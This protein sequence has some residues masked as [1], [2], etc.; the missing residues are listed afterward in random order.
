MR[1]LQSLLLPIMFVLFG[2]N[3]LAFSSL[4]GASWQSNVFVITG[5]AA[6]I[7]GVALLLDQV[8]VAKSDQ[9]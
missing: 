3:W 4:F 2:V 5:F 1:D 9:K 7:I 8:P 6:L